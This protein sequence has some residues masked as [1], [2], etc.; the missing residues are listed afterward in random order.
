MTTNNTL[1]EHDAYHLKSHSLIYAS[2]DLTSKMM[3]IFALMLTRMRECDWEDENGHEI[4]PDYTFNSSELCEFF[5]VEKK[6]LYAAIQ[7]PSQG[8][9]QKE[10]GIEENGQFRY[11][12]ILSEISYTNGTLTITPNGKLRKTYIINAS[13]NGHAKIDNKFFK[14][15]R[16]PNTK[17][18]FEFLSRYRYDKEMYHLKISKLQTMFGV[19]GKKGEV[20]K[21]SYELQSAF[22]YKVIEPSLVEIANSLEAKGK[23]EVLAKNGRLGYE[24]IEKPNNESLIKFNVRWL[25]QVP[26]DKVKEAT[27]KVLELMQEVNVASKSGDKVELD[28]L[29]KLEKNL[30]LI[31][32]DEQADTI[33]QKVADRKEQVAIEREREAKEAEENEMSKV[34]ELLAKGFLDSL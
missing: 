27:K 17:K 16:N 25:N 5:Q 7:R 24:I 26:K 11:R 18:V 2:T 30:R 1:E 10:I 3:D 8:L 14:A 32:R 13:D 12:P 4:V 20:K 34:D 15:L 29:I 6:Q 33:R 28:V 23:L 31:G 9:A 19:F 21:K 22:I